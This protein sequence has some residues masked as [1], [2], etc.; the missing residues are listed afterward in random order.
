MRELIQAA[1]PESGD[2]RIHGDPKYFTEYLDLSYAVLVM[3]LKVSHHTDQPFNL[4]FP[5]ALRGSYDEK[6]VACEG[7]SYGLWLKGCRMGVI[8]LVT[9]RI[10]QEVCWL[11]WSILSNILLPG[12][13]PKPRSAI[14]VPSGLLLTGYSSGLCKLVEGGK[15]QPRPLGHG[16]QL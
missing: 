4:T 11:L 14:S 12:N 8:L 10:T 1:P 15:A 9:A 16:I 6:E 2:L 3:Q 7:G 13:T 5:S